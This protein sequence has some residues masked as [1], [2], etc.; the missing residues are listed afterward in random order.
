[1]TSSF[2]EF[3]ES[4][5]GVVSHTITQTTEYVVNLDDSCKKILILYIFLSFLNFSLCIYNDGKEALLVYRNSIIV[6][7]A[8]EWKKVRGACFKD[9]YSHVINS[10]I[11]PIT[12]SLNIMPWFIIYT[13]SSVEYSSKYIN[14]NEEESE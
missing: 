10:L 6:N 14:D 5:N 13:S 1:M 11:W 8:M 4:V 7:Q 2:K 9:T 12:F 3:Y